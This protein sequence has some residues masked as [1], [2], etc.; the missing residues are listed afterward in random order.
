MS[1][2]VRRVGVLVNYSALVLLIAFFYTAERTHI[3]VF[4]IS[5]IL[6]ALFVVIAS[7]LYVHG[8]TGLWRLVHTN[9]DNLD[10]REIQVVH[11]SLRQSYSAFS[12][13]CLSIV[14]ASELIE[15]FVS[16]VVDI[17]LLPIF[18]GL[19]YLAHTLPSSLIAWTEKRM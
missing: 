13:I 1:K 11:I 3:N 5:G 14:L 12:I 19:L 15:E 6:V 10:E 17:P 2:S 8:K 9:I 4:W 7:C 16:G 18:V